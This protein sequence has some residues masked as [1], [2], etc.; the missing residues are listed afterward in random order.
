MEN[1]TS[2]NNSRENLKQSFYP[3]YKKQS[4]EEIY[5]DLNLLL[6]KEI[7]I[8]ALIN[9]YDNLSTKSINVLKDLQKEKNLRI[10]LE[11]VKDLNKTPF[12]LKEYNKELNISALCHIDG[13]TM[14]Y[15]GAEEIFFELVYIGDN[16]LDSLRSI[17][18]AKKSQ[19]N[20]GIIST[21]KDFNISNFLLAS[22]EIQRNSLEVLDYELQVKDPLFIEKS[23]YYMGDLAIIFFSVSIFILILV[24]GIFKKWSRENFF[25]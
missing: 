20:I 24:I 2:K 16:P 18:E 17:E 11:D 7:P 19:E 15:L 21:S 12:I 14:A 3:I 10:A 4:S 6:N 1:I 22:K 8:M 5:E 25:D 23:F 13:S 9:P